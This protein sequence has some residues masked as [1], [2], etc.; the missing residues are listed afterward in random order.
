MNKKSSDIPIAKAFIYNGDYY[1]YDTCKNQLLS[2]TREHYIEI[3]E[4]LHIGM[5]KYKALNKSSKT[6]TDILMLVNK[7]YFKP[8]CV[9]AIIHPESDYISSALDRGI[10]DLT[11]Q[12]TKNC[13]FNCRYC[14]Y[15]A[16]SKL[17]RTHERVNMQWDIAQ[18]SLDYLITHSK[19]IDKIT[20]AFYG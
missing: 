8:V 6:Y 3:I 5:T 4:M 19:D 10:N 2:V 13:N 11:L 14:L 1:V 17:E 20:V 18:K 7:G 12:V 9:E 16:K 15:A